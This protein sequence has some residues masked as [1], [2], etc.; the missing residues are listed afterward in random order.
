MPRHRTFAV[1]ILTTAHSMLPSLSASMPALVSNAGSRGMS[2]PS[3]FSSVGGE[4]RGA[5][6]FGFRGSMQLP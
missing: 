4:A 6:A 5:H 1:V 2:I 3:P